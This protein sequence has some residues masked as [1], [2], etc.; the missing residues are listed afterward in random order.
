MISELHWTVPCKQAS[1]QQGWIQSFVF[2][3]WPISLIASPFFIVYMTFSPLCSFFC[4]RFGHFIW[5]LSLF[6]RLLFA[7]SSH[8]I[9]LETSVS[10]FEKPRGP[11]CFDILKIKLVK[12]VK[13]VQVT[14]MSRMKRTKT[15]FE[16]LW[17]LLTHLDRCAQL[18]RV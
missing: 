8:A 17:K 9:S 4:L 6:S 15:L 13:L 3:L 16:L 5:H 2:A 14:A 10:N 11:V 1:L 18:G 12:L 7:H